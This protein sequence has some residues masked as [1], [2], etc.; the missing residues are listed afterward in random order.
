MIRVLLTRQLGV[1]RT[2]K[3]GLRMCLQTSEILCAESTCFSSLEECKDFRVWKTRST[4]ILYA[5]SRCS[6]ID[7]TYIDCCR[8]LTCAQVSEMISISEHPENPQIFDE[9]LAFRYCG[10]L[11]LHAT[12]L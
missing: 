8:F 5:F 10:S 4:Q 3:I 1:L 12:L 2:R 9:P 6:E 7:A 11:S